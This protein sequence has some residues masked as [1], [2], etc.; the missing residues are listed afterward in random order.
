MTK[1]T[2]AN[3]M[4]TPIHVVSCIVGVLRQ[5]FGTEDR[6]AIDSSKYIWRADSKKTNVY[7]S[8]EFNDL[9]NAVGIRPMILVGFPQSTFSKDVIGDF[10]EYMPDGGEVR[11]IGRTIG[12]I[13]LRC[14][15]DKALASMELATEVKY[16]INVF[17]HQIQCAHRIDQLRPNSMQG[18]ARIEEYK[19]YWTTD[20]VCDI[21]YQENWSIA[22]ETLKIK[23]I[24]IQLNS[25]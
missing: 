16:F 18:P 3:F 13:R 22:I 25:K 4:M 19:E 7:I 24:G 21:L 11:N 14:I 17:R 9:R 20:C 15:S 2:Q 1:N 10:L 23:S 8:E 6:I 12:Q 5:Y